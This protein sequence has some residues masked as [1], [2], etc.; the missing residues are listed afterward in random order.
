MANFTDRIFNNYLKVTKLYMR[1]HN[2]IKT[3]IKSNSYELETPQW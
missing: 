2:N 1:V 3:K